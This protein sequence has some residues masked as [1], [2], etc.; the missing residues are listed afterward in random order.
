MSENR[1]LPDVV[2]E[3]ISLWLDAV[4]HGCHR[5]LS[6]AA[7]LGREFRADVLGALSSKVALENPDEAV[8][9]Q[10]VMVVSPATGEYRF[11][12]ALIQRYLY[13]GISPLELRA[14]QGMAASALESYY[15]ERAADHAAEIVGHLSR[16][17]ASA[18]FDDVVRYSIVAGFQ[19]LATY[20]WRCA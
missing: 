16:A 7:V 14:E 10:L 12:H 5:L 1:A 9:R 13:D 2:Q 6:T 17:G 18:A 20:S 19:S 3:V 8:E 15:E 11:A 4:S